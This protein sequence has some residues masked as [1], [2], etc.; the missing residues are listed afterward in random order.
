VIYAL[1]ALVIVVGFL[2]YA[3]GYERGRRERGT[4]GRVL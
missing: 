1:P 3:L 2:T 4:K